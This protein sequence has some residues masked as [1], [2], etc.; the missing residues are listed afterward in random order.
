LI[1]QKGNGV[2]FKSYRCR[3]HC[4]G[5]LSHTKQR[6]NYGFVIGC[7][8]T[9]IDVTD[10]GGIAGAFYRKGLRYGRLV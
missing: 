8:V 10:L 6:P 9:N 2:S 4:R 3:K 1:G 7:D 5:L